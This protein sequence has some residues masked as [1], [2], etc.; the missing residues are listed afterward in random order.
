MAKVIM[1]QTGIQRALTR[2]TY[3]IIEQNRGLTNLIIVG[4][5]RGVR[6]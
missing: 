2:I 1:D 5:V 6:I 4:F 3:E